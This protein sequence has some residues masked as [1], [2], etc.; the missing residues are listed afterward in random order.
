MRVEAARRWR[1]AR[2]C[3]VEPLRHVGQRGGLKRRK[4]A[5][6][7]KERH[8]RNS[9]LSQDVNQRI[10]GSICQVVLVL[11][12]DDLADSSSRR[13]L[14]WRHAAQPDMA[15]E[16]L[17]L[18]VGERGETCSRSTSVRLSSTPN[19]LRRLT[20]SRAST[21]RLRRLSC[22]ALTNSFGDDAA[23]TDPSVPRRAPTLVTMTRSSG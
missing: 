19:M 7:R 23:R 20:T 12:A 9:V 1:P 6:E 11:N 21:P 8:V 16:S 3:D 10:V 18:E 13:E 17:A 5:A 4:A 22:T 2:V 15:D 14:L